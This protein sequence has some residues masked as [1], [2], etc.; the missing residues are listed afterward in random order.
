M[1]TTP[2][3]QPSVQSTPPPTPQAR[4]ARHAPG[5]AAGR[6]RYA[7][8]LRDLAAGVTDLHDFAAR[9][10]M[11]RLALAKWTSRPRHAA[12]IDELAVLAE[13][14]AALLLATSRADAARTLKEIAL[15]PDIKARD[16][17][18]KACVDLLKLHR[19][20]TPRAAAPGRP[21]PEPDFDEPTRE[22]VRA[23][24]EQ[25]RRD[26]FDDETRAPDSD[27]ASDSAG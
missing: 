26:D 14:R 13:R 11:S 5:V 22:E 7:A 24:L 27:P 8:M 2:S 16:V 23:A 15:D 9:H 12:I 17:A 3:D 6:N 25:Y 1:T 21:T 10:S 19:V 4:A 20:S 18:R